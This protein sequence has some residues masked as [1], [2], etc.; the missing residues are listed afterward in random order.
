MRIGLYYG[1]PDAREALHRL[2]HFA[3]ASRIATIAPGVLGLSLLAPLVLRDGPSV[4]RARRA[5][6]LAA[7]AW[8]AAGVACFGLLGRPDVPYLLAFWP[9]AI[10]LAALVL[11]RIAEGGGRPLERPALPVFG[12]AFALAFVAFD[13]AADAAILDGVLGDPYYMTDSRFSRTL[14][15]AAI[16]A[17]LA[18][19]L[20]VAATARA[21]ARAGAAGEGQVER[22]P[23]P[24]LAA[25]I[26]GVVLTWQI[27][28]ICGAVASPAWTLEAARRD[29]LAILPRE[30]R[31]GEHFAHTLLLDAPP[32]GPVPRYALASARGDRELAS[33]VEGDLTHVAA[34]ADRFSELVRSSVA[35]AR[36]G[37]PVAVASLY[38]RGV[39]VRIAR[40]ADATLPPGPFEAARERI[41]RGRPADAVPLLEG[42]AESFPRSELVR[43]HLAAAR[44]LAGDLSGARRALEPGVAND[45]VAGLVVTAFVAL[46]AGEP[47]A[48]LA[49]MERLCAIYT[50]TRDVERF[51]T[52][53][54]DAIGGGDA[55][56]LRALAG[57]RAE[58]LVKD[59][60]R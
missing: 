51:R 33:G 46:R 40:L 17:G 45:S 7:G 22:S 39:R 5:L 34:A 27:V 28:L 47:A 9:G 31:L 16:A 53:L 37:A 56:R 18:A 49:A 35:G 43:V 13:V 24:R 52:D 58:L 2:A 19:A 4:G 1:A 14:V 11:A 44:A 54:A 48:G 38:L 12:V 20:A 23:R 36:G 26:G 15:A 25:T 8:V 55:A 57:T 10:L 42:C 30:A 59:L 50:W 6:E 21:R 32:G 3:A 60:L 29:V 41:E